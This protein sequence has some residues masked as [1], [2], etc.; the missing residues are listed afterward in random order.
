MPRVFYAVLAD[1]A[2]REWLQ[3]RLPEWMPGPWT[4]GAL[5]VQGTSAN[6]PV[7]EVMRAPV[8]VPP[9]N[10]HLTLAFVG[11]V[12]EA[13]VGELERIGAALHAE[14]STVVFDG[15][16]HWRRARM[17]ALIAHHPPPALL[18]LRTRLVEALRAAGV[19]VDALEPF[20]PHVT[21]AR[22]VAQ[23]PVMT[24]DA[25]E[26]ALEWPVRAVTLLASDTSGK[27]SR[28]TVLATWPLLDRR[29]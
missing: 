1:D 9:A 11:A 21:L 16:E 10:Y 25:R 18:G 5:G 29:A 23:A 12:T 22:K 4:A 3:A 26:V 17:L 27:T 8:P 7:P 20:R 28:Y 2:S 13:R 14:A 15:V 19:A 6:T 24:Q